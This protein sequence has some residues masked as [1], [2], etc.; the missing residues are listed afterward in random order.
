MKCGCAAQKF[1]AS[2]L[3][4][5]P[6]SIEILTK[7]IL[8]FSGIPLGGPQY[9]KVQFTSLHKFQMRSDCS[10]MSSVMNDFVVPSRE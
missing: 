5:P 3:D 7:F 9:A 1:S 10:A 6:F 2:S 8:I 4:I